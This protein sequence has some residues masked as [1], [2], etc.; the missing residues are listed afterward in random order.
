MSSRRRAVAAAVLLSV[1]AIA[2]APRT[3][4]AQAT[5]S[6]TSA[7][8]LPSVTLPSALDRVLRDF[9]TQWR[10]ENKRGV[11]ALYTTDGFLLSDGRPPVR[12][13]SAIEAT[14]QAS[15]ALHLRAL[16]FASEG[17]LGWIVGGYRWGNETIDAGK[18][19]LLLKRDATG[20]WLI[21]ADIDNANRR[22]RP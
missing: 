19:V 1:A 14:S 3:A 8:D 16:S 11:A 7:P 17:D 12:G 2:T 5:A 20:K 10:A 22:A 21:A 15:G 6:S 13:R 9:E 18:F 4:R